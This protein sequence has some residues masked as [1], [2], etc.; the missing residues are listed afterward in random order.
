[1]QTLFWKKFHVCYWSVVKIF[2]PHQND[3]GLIPGSGRF[4]CVAMLFC[5]SSGNLWSINFLAI[6]SIRMH[7]AFCKNCVRREVLWIHMISIIILLCGQTGNTIWGSCDSSM[8]TTIAPSRHWTV[9][10]CIDALPM[11][12][13]KQARHPKIFFASRCTCLRSDINFYHH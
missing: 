11:E 1:M 9:I 5:R 4:F 7:G 8:V 13:G 12:F 3:P 2:R 6:V 10:L